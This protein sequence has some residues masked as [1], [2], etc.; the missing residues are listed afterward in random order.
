[1]VFNLIFL[2]SEEGKAEMLWHSGVYIP[3]THTEWK[4]HFS[5]H[6]VMTSHKWRLSQI[7]FLIPY[8]QWYQPDVI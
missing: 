3:L 5:L 6:P 7:Y 8:H 4:S 2:C 1:V